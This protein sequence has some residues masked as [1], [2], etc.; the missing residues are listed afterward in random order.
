MDAFTISDKIKP[1]ATIVSNEF[2]DAYM[3]Q[4]NGEYIKVFLMFLRLTQSKEEVS[5]SIIANHLDMTER[6]VAR[7]FEYWEE[8]GLLFVSSK[9]QTQGKQEKAKEEPKKIQEKASIEKKAEQE[10]N[11]LPAADIHSLEKQ[12]SSPS[13]VELANAE[14]PKEASIA[15]GSS[16]EVSTR[17]VPIKMELSPL[18]L[19]D[20]FNDEDFCHLKYIAEMYLGHP[21]T[22][23]ELNSLSYIYD[24]LKMQKDLVEYLI[25]YCVSNHKPSLRYMEKVAI[26]WH[27]KDIHTLA[28][29]KSQAT[30]FGKD[31]YRIMKALGLHNQPAPSQI[32]IMDQWLHEDGFSI[33][34]ILEAC[35]RTINA[36]GKPSFPYVSKILE[37]WKEDGIHTLQEV[38][39][40]EKTHSAIS[41]TSKQLREQS[42]IS[43]RKTN[44]PNFQQR[45]Y[46]FD[47]LTAKFIKK[48]NQ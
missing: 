33:N 20:K 9:E 7:A 45:S 36:I 3:T 43:T 10:E 23:A 48:I 44:Q 15:D 1:S 11:S 12:I 30:T 18:D 32:E 38:Q 14:K 19:D 8:E 35:K 13:K 31:Y 5:F 40:A 42:Q 16:N 17:K 6:A 25:E 46:D 37:R 39:E 47:A 34:L 24:D 21:M 29:A 4:A 2:I 22:G 28:E 41:S 27:Q 26:D